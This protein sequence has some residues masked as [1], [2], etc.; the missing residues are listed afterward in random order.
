MEKFSISYLATI[1]L[2]LT[3]AIVNNAYASKEYGI[4][5]EVNSINSFPQIAEQISIQTGYNIIFDE[6]IINEKINIKYTNQ[7]VEKF[8]RRILKDKNYSVIFD[9]QKHTISIRLFGNKRGRVFNISSTSSSEKKD[10]ISDKKYAVINAGL[11]KAKENITLAMNNKNTKEPF[12][13]QSYY[14]INKSIELQSK[15]YEVP[16]QKDN[17]T[18]KSYAKI[19]NSLLKAKSKIL[20]KNSID[21]TTGLTY[22]QINNS[23]KKAQENMRYMSNSEKFIDPISGISYKEINNSLK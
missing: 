10:K 14:E 7:P 9:E 17:V 15:R 2:Y 18:G 16:G 8:L 23:L 19:N 5:N 20:G 4:R 13:G 12:S 22:S 21:S 6:A 11:K 3:V 1:T